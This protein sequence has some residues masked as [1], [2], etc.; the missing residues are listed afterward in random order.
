MET[1]KNSYQKIFKSTSIVGGS[2]V[3]IIILG[4]IRTKF[5]A[6]L[7]GPMGVGIIGIMQTII[8]MVRNATGFGIN[9]S[10]VKY[11]AE[12]SVTED[13]TKIS[14]TIRVLRRWAWGTGILGMIVTIIFCIPLSKYSFG[15]NSYAISIAI[16]SIVLLISSIS[17]AQIALLQGLRMIG[18]MAK[19]SLIGAILGT[20]ITL[21]LYWWLGINGI[22]PG[23][24]LTAIVSLII[25]WSFARTVKIRLDKI[26]I[27]E[28]FNSGL[29]MAKLGFF[30]VV[31]GL[32]AAVSIYII[33]ALVMSKL[34]VNSVGYFQA[35]MTISTLY[36]N[37]L[38]NSMLADFF[39]RLSMVNADNAAATKLI[40]EQ[41]ELT[42]LFGTPMIIGMITFSNI[43]INLLY[44]SSFSPAIPVLQWQM[45][46]SF[47]TFISWPLGVMFLA[48]DKGKYAIM[49]E[50]IKQLMFVLIVF[51][52]F[53][54]FGLKV[55]G[56][57]FFIAS[58][59]YMLLVIPSVKYLGEFKFSK[60]NINY[61]L[62]G[63]VSVLTV[64]LCSLFI[65]SMISKY[66]INISLC[67]I[68]SVFYIR[69]INVLL[70]TKGLL[71]KLFYKK[72]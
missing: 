43:I 53:D 6:I 48:K 58:F 38:L 23:L 32:V 22:V 12:A 41:L 49:I 39:P 36:I 21:P 51:V 72:K 5:V 59:V 66:V 60:T 67:I 52:F 7:L 33:R 47:M 4:I 63:C 71:L 55:L 25:S 26:S 44:S 28:S 20:V 61:I 11:I 10:S 19:A 13:S 64:L 62:I 18:K 2:Q 68:I 69:K 54:F 31:N 50:L 34:G 40:N 27:L 16:L 14:K 30:I 37:I 42:L 15:D 1:E 45:A 70:D 29:K 3:F 57:G 35:V 17:S 56:I 9:F 65:S 24:I 46:A 8:D